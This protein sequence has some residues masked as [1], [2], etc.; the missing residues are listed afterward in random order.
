MLSKEGKV[1]LVVC[2]ISLV[3]LGLAPT[4]QKR[5]SILGTQYKLV[6]HV[7]QGLREGDP[8]KVGGV[9]AGRVINLDFAPV[10]DWPKLNPPGD[11]RPA[12]LVTVALQQGFKLSPGSG[13][14]VVSTLRGTHFINILP[15]PPTSEVSPGSILNQELPGEAD[16]QLMATIKGFKVLSQRTKDMR[17]Q[18]GD[19]VFRRDMKD[20][21]S[22]MRFY[23]N[24]FLRVSQDSKHQVKEIQQ[25]LD[26]QEASLL[27]NVQ[28]MD[29]Q[30]ARASSYLRSMVPSLRQQVASYRRQMNSSQKQLDK[31]YATAESYN[32]KF[33]DFQKQLQDGPIGKLDHEKIAQ[34]VH[35]TKN[36]IEFYADLTQ[37]MHTV[38][39]DAQIQRDFKA[40]PKKYKNQSE[41]WKD[42]AR[43]LEEQ[44]D[45]FRWLGNPDPSPTPS[46]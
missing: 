3:M 41:K 26:E 30:T 34:D 19:P 7:C 14:K 18:F 42:Q 13:Y 32:K 24:E 36:K 29:N 12:V 33:R 31:M 4:Q 9:E 43:K 37:D 45:N 28:K 46:P 17:E 8:V 39:S 44:V 21:A 10:E 2:S 5:P 35:D 23:S 38:T 15:S 6:F 40:I 11:E 25:R 16:D 27:G 1:G 22:N 20:L